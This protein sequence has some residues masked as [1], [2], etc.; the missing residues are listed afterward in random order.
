MKKVLKVNQYGE[1]LK[2]RQEGTA[3]SVLTVIEFYI[4]YFIL[5]YRNGIS[6]V[7]KDLVII[8]F[9]SRNQALEFYES[10]NIDFF[11]MRASAIPDIW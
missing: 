2:I 7:K 1:K 6:K 11:P 4:E 9:A 10:L 5:K 8:L 3:F